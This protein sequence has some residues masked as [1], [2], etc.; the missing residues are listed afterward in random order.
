MRY[1]ISLL[2][3]AILLT[4]CGKQNPNPPDPLLEKGEQAFVGLYKLENVLLGPGQLVQPHPETSELPALG[5]SPEQAAQRG[6][7]TSGQ[8]AALQQADCT[9]TVLTDHSF[10]MTNLP[11]ADFSQSINFK[12]TWSLQVYHVF[13]TYGYRISMKGGPKG[14]LALAKFSNADKPSSLGFEIYY[15]Q[16]HQGQVAFRFTRAKAPAPAQP[17][18]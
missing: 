1:S 8:A 6:L 3:L 9:L 5:D 11:A 18:R 17:S 7:L 15:R 12:G 13:D 4:G 2:F 16:G 14:D 10:T